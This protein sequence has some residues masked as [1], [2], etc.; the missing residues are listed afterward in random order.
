MNS[1]IDLDLILVSVSGGVCVMY[2]INTRI[3]ELLKRLEFR[4]G[5]DLSALFICTF[6]RAV[7]LWGALSPAAFFGAFV[8]SELYLIWGL[9]M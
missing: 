9:V 5:W 1:C 7:E 4:M 3:R 6:P 2:H 8:V